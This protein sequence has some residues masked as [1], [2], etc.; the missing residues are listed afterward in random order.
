MAR[1]L[2]REPLDACWV[3]TNPTSKCP[4][5]EVDG[6]TVLAPVQGDSHVDYWNWDATYDTEAIDKHGVPTL[7]AQMARVVFPRRTDELGKMPA[8]LAQK[9]HPNVH[10]KGFTPHPTAEMVEALHD[11][12]FQMNW[13]NASPVRR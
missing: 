6:A 12:V 11:F 5:E 9:G 7:T 1:H 13:W 3:F 2:E 8:G 10:G 4:T